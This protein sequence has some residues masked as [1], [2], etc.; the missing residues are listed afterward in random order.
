M[1]ATIIRGPEPLR[2]SDPSGKAHVDA[3]GKCHNVA[4]T[5]DEA[6]WCCVEAWRCQCG[7]EV[8]KKPQ[9]FG[10][11]YRLC[12]PC[13]SKRWAAECAT[14][15]SALRAK[16]KRIPWREYGGWVSDGRTLFP[17]VDDW[18]DQFDDTDE[19]PESLW[20]CDEITLYINRSRAGRNRTRASST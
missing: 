4:R 11:R 2:L 17:S 7:A 16:A 19:F 9:Y 14:R 6:R 8:T 5:E 1:T 13:E 20:A 12:P 3:C 10:E 15:D 18:W